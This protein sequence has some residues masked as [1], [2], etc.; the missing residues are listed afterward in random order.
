MIPVPHEVMSGFVRL[1]VVRG[2]SQ[3]QVKYYQKW[4]R[5]YYDFADK[6]LQGQGNAEKVRQF[7]DKLKNKGQQFLFLRIPWKAV[8]ATARQIMS[9][10][11]Q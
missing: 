1:L 6:Y 4:L 10:S 8:P 7:L 2:I 11:F 3:G 5:Y 9:G